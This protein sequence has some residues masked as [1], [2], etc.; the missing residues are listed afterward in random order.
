MPASS[1]DD[2]DDM[3]VLMDVCCQFIEEEVH[4]IGVASLK[5]E[6]GSSPIVRTD[7]TKDVA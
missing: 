5:Q 7:G 3:L 1:I 4:S 6:S 2:E